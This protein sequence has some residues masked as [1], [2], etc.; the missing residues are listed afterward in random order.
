MKKVLSKKL[1]YF[2]LLFPFF[3]VQS[4]AADITSG[5]RGK[6]TALLN[7]GENIIS[8]G[9]DGFIVI[10]NTGQRAAV[11]RFQLTTDRI[12]AL[13]IHPLRKE[14]C[15]T[16]TDGIGS[17]RISAWNYTLKKKLFSVN[18]TESVTYINYSAGGSFIIAA[19]FDGASLTLLNSETGEIVSVPE[20]SHGSVALAVTGRAEQ[21]MMLYQANYK[22][23]LDNEFTYLQHEGQILYLEL[24]SGSVSNRFPAPENLLNPFLFGNNRFIAGINSRGLLIVN[25]VTGEILDSAENIQRDAL[26]CAS[27]DGF[28][29][30]S[31][32]NN[33]FVL[34]HYTVD[35]NGKL[36]MRRQISLP[37]D[38]ANQIHQ[39]AYNKNVILAS[40]QGLLLLDGQ[41]RIIPMTTGKQTRIT[42]IAA[43]EKTAALLTE[44]GDLFFLPLDYNLIK[45][46]VTLNIK[47]NGS[48]T[49]ITPIPPLSEKNTD[50][51]LLWQTDNTKSIPQIAYS[52]HSINDLNLNFMVGRF[53]LRSISTGYGNILT[54]DYAGNLSVYNLEKLS[55][56][57]DFSYTS[58]GANDA[59][60]INNQYIVLSR[61]TANN[62][63]PFLFINYKTGET[64]RV[65]YNIQ[66]GLTVY[67]GNSG[68]I[69]AESIEQEE[70]KIKTVIL[71]LSLTNVPVR[72]FEYQ[73][74]ATNLS[75]VESSKIPA[76]ACDNEGAFIIGEKIIYFERTSGLPIKLLGCEKIFISLDSEGNISWHDN[77]DGKILAVFSLYP[78][79]WKMMKKTDNREI[80]G[81]FSRQ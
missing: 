21:N 42:E 45:N 36:V 15:I 26:L 10:W 41:N 55:A 29:C 76:I 63:S 38:T 9:E 13:A 1:F 7:I 46:N 64:V 18:S 52:N 39:L 14:I 4:F 30:L 51:F 57:A 49:R 47:N 66:T 32:T 61:S 48:F 79:Q 40:A 72:I 54:L 5:H 73:G 70:N 80:S 3:A 35:R 24:E 23:Y 75:I 19:G 43:G 71:G 33:S 2:F 20:I 60:F 69:Y 56:K 25:A 37:F 44:D 34:Y 11:E 59:V 62:N 12:E 67:A 17:Y 58:P 50:R 68:N 8:T 77:R 28:Y 74:E 81:K 53:P 31:R 27:D 6:I 16:E 78:D 22:N 65:P